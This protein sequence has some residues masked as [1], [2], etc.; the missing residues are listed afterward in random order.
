MGEGQLPLESLLT[1]KF[2][3]SPRKI[4]SPSRE[5]FPVVPPGTLS[6][7]KAFSF[8]SGTSPP[9]HVMP[10][11]VGRCSTLFRGRK[12][13]WKKKRWTDPRAH[14]HVFQEFSFLPPLTPARG[15][16][17][18]SNT[19]PPSKRITSPLT[20]KPADMEEIMRDPQRET[21]CIYTAQCAT[22]LAFCLVLRLG[23]IG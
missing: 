20:V 3:S 5:T 7:W 6:S 18:H 8:N 16:S 4:A 9:L 12:N 21:F 2:T 17:R 13:S 10:S 23:H 19:R 11:N 22:P 14:M 15:F 1:L